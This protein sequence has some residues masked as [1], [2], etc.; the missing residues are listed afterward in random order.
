MSLHNDYVVAI[1]AKQRHKELL[2]RAAEDRLARLVPRPAPWW[3]RLLGQSGKAGW[4]RRRSSLDT[5][6]T[7]PVGMTHAC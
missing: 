4:R 5:G 1:V 7:D 2:A 3:R 6:R